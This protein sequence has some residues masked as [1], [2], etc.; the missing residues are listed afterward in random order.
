M[1]LGV[2]ARKRAHQSCAFTSSSIL[3]PD[4]A[5]Y[6]RQGLATKLLDHVY[7][8][9]TEASRAAANSPLTSTTTT[10]S[11][12]ATKSKADKGKGK[13]VDP[14]PSAPS[15]PAP[16]LKS[17]FVHVQVSN[18]DSKAF[19]LQQGFKETETVKDYYKENI[20]GPRSAWLLEKE[21]NSQ[22]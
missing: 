20:E 2:L 18:E 16:V 10:A 8:K 22:S 9:A 3:I 6:R 4:F 13:A 1:T 14:T 17:I 5:A 7:E 11:A 15:P 21:I 19:W 12:K